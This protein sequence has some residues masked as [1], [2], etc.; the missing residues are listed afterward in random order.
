MDIAILGLKAPFVL[1]FNDFKYATV[2]ANNAKAKH[3]AVQ[4]TEHNA[5]LKRNTITIAK[6][7][8]KYADIAVFDRNAMFVFDYKDM[9][10]DSSNPRP[11][12]GTWFRETDAMPAR[13]HTFRSMLLGLLIRGLQRNGF[14]N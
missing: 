3:D 7:T 5:H 12:K 11:A 6:Q 13:G 14:I 4:V 10:Y 1:K 8:R 2:T 9:D